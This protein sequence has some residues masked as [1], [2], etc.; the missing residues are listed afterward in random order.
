MRHTFELTCKWASN[1]LIGLSATG[2]IAMTIIVAWQVFGRYVLNSSPSW[3][4][5]AALVLIIW[6]VSLAAA[7]GV[8]EG[9]HIRIVSIE[10]AS[11]PGV[12]RLLQLTANAVVALCGFAMLLWGSELVS[13]TWSHGIPSLG[14][15]RGLSYLGIPIAGALIM[16]FAAERILAI[17]SPEPDADEKGI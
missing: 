2:L 6:F 14:I 4:E 12:R 10:E 1:L 5:Q 15:P 9:F 8:R 13:R 17:C 11:A 7:A 16:L 3:S